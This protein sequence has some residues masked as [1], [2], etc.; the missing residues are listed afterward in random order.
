MTFSVTIIGLNQVGASIGLALAQYKDKISTIGFDRDNSRIKAAKRDQVVDQVAGSLFAAIKTSDLVLLCEEYRE[1]VESLQLVTET[2]LDGKYLFDIGWNKQAIDLQLQNQ[3]PGFQHSLH[4]QLTKNPKYLLGDLVNDDLPHAD[5]FEHGTMALAT[6]ST[7]SAEA[8]DLATTLA[9]MLKTEMMFCDLAEL[10]GLLSGSQQFPYLLAASLSEA[11]NAQ[12]GWMEAQKLTGNA[13]YQLAGPLSDSSAFK[14]DADSFFAN[15][16]NLIHW[17]DTEMNELQ[18]LRDILAAEDEKLFKEWYEQAQGKYQ[19]L[20]DRCSHAD[21]GQKPSDVER[22][23]I[24]AR[25]G[26]LIGLHS[27]KTT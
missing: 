12:P 18:R 19:I 3:A 15:R 8:V 5:L 2:K 10:D 16:S 4:F 17:V 7:T 26:R 23:S 27:K 6:T 21:W 13:F 14:A 24:S 22:E 9:R 11:A 25:L 20:V 1:L